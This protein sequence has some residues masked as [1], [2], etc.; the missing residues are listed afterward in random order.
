MTI[1]R[2]LK[3]YREEVCYDLPNSSGK[4]LQIKTVM[5]LPKY[6]GFTYEKIA[7]GKAKT[8]AK[9]QIRT[10]VKIVRALKP[11]KWRRIGF[12]MTQDL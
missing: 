3:F 7:P 2:H 1:L 8:I 5:F 4:G 11:A 10:A 12:T 9:T 6:I